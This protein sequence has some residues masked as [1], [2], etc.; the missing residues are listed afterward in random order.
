MGPGPD[1]D[2]HQPAPDPRAADRGGQARGGSPRPG[3]RERGAG[4]AAARASPAAHTRPPRPRQRGLGGKNRWSTG[5]GALGQASEALLEYRVRLLRTPWHLEVRSSGL[6][7]TSLPSPRWFWDSNGDYSPDASAYTI[8][9]AG[10][11]SYWTSGREARI[12]AAVTEWRTTDWNPGIDLTAAPSNC[13]A[14]LTCQGLGSMERR[15]AARSAGRT[16]S[17]QPIVGNGTS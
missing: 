2:L 7:Q 8:R 3:C 16:V 15:R 13:Y 4:R 17:S 9:T 6:A 1:R 10:N 14:L 11:D 12:S 5:P